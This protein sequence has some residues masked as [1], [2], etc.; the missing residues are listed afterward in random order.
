M[1]IYHSWKQIRDLGIKKH[2]SGENV[3]RGSFLR[4]SDWFSV[5]I[6]INDPNAGFYN[7][8]K[9]AASMQ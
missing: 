8:I 3:N 1:G 4:V 2:F 7:A 5:K 6:L 9:V